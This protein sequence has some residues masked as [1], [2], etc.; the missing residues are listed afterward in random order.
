MVEQ[1]SKKIKLTFITGNKKKLEEFLSI[2]TDS[3]SHIYE[4][5]NKEV[6]CKYYFNANMYAISG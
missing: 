3:L 1:L 5:T 6:D 2:M 4:V